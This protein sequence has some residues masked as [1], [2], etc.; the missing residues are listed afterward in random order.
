MIESWYKPLFISKEDGASLSNS[1]TETSILPP[2]IKI[3]IPGGFFELIGQRIK[4]TAMGRISNIV[5]TPGTLTLKL[6]FG[7]NIIWNSGAFNLNVVAKTTVPW[8]LDLELSLRAIGASANF[9]PIGAF[10]SESVVGSPANTA[11]GNG[12]LMLPVGAPVVGANFDSTASQILDLSA[13]FS[14][15]NAGNLIQCHMFEMSSKF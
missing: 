8:W 14:V 9:L 13:T 3:P 1:T 2:S 5:T 10:T 12:S 4:V 7:S 11:G 15:A 6:K